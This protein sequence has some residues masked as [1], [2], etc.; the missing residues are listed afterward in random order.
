MVVGSDFLTVKLIWGGAVLK[1]SGSAAVVSVLRD[2]S[3]I[4]YADPLMVRQTHF[5]QN[6]PT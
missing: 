2:R 1:T 5:E 4:T 3:H 6:R